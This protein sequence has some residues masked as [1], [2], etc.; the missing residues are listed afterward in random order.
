VLTLLICGAVY[1]A[2]L[3]VCAVVDHRLGS[4]LPARPVDHSAAARVRAL[5]APPRA[6][7]ACGR[8]RRRWDGVQ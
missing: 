1:L 6:G 3:G 7:E 2:W 8:H 4:R 5:Q